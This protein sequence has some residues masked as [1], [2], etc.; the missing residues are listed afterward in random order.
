MEG[1]IIKGIAGFYY[2]AAE[3]GRIYECKAKGVFRKDRK[4]PLV[5]D[6][7]FMDIVDDKTQTG[8]V[9]ELLERRNEL[10]RPAVANVDQALVIFA[11]T[12]PEPNFGLLN[13]FLVYLESEGIPAVI[14]FNKSDLVGEFERNELRAAFCG[15]P[16]PVLFTC[17]K[18]GEGI[19]E[20]KKCL[21]GK[22]STMAGPS[23]VGK[24][25]LINCLQ[26]KTVMET[27]AVSKKLGRGRHTTRHVQLLPLDKETY[28][29]DTPGFSSLELAQLG[30]R[31]ITDAF[32]EIAAYS[33]KCRFPDCVHI[34][35]P[36]CK[37]K[38]AVD[39]GRISKSRYESYVSLFEACKERKKR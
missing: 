31:D 36:G 20:L 33:G 19:D 3:S 15:S 37:C 34:R 7:V 35:E 38:E 9:T 27:G 18:T 23:G 13:R 6:R 26:E 29:F 1:R 25:S 32:P 24:S 5:G 14:C 2:V 17:A 10:L 4:K 8:N 21:S 11:A 39:N 28:I 22:V 30:E 12:N 16:Y